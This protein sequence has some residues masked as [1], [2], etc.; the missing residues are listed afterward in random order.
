VPLVVFFQGSLLIAVVVAAFAISFLVGLVVAHVSAPPVGL[1][2]PED[3][4]HP[5][6]TW[7]HDPSAP[8]R[9]RRPSEILAP[10]DDPV[11]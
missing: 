2:S 9:G 6:H 7:P 1:G 4:L 8:P 3:G 11:V 10:V 5:R